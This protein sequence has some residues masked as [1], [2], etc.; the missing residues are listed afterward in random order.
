MKKNELSNSLITV[1]EL[2]KRLRKTRQTIHNWTKAELIPSYKI[3]GSLFY[4]FEEVVNAI[5]E[6]GCNG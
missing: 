4:D 3:G 6:G 5:K 2:A 1:A